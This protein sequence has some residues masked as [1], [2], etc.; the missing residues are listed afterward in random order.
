MDKNIINNVN[1]RE[2]QQ[3]R[4]IWI[5][6]LIVLIA[7]ITWYGFFQQIIFRRPFGSNPAPD[8]VMWIIWIV[9]GIGFPL[10]FH[11]TRLI[12]EVREDGVYIRFFPLHYRFHRI[13]FAELKSY[14][15]RNYSPIKEYGG[16]GIR[17][18]VKGKA[19]MENEY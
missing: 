19:Y 4:Q 3:F 6:F 8:L 16:W 14:E 13:P 10:L 9:V 2:V 18:G 17:Y 11:A 12:V 7:G 1:Y 5:W 15:V